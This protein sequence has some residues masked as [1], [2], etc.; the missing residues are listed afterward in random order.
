MALDA[1]LI[2]ILVA[3]LIAAI[4]LCSVANWLKRNFEKRAFRNVRLFFNQVNSKA[5]PEQVCRETQIATKT[6]P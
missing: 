5:S 6:K 2:G 1:W 3:L 4:V